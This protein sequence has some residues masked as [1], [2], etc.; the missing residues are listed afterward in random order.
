MFQLFYSLIDL[1]FDIESVIEGKKEHRIILQFCFGGNHFS[2]IAF[3]SVYHLENFFFGRTAKDAQ[4]DVGR[5]QIFAHRYVSDGDKTGC[6][7]LNGFDKQP[8]QLF[9]YDIRNFFL[10]SAFL[11][12][13]S[14]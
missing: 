5:L 8:A 9:A 4:I 3:P 11:Q 10:S 1:I 13:F 6:N 7:V 2:E 12:R 14:R